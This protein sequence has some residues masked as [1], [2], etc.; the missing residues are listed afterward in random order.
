[1]SQINHKDL[2][3]CFF[4]LNLLNVVRIATIFAV[5][6]SMK[7]RLKSMGKR[8]AHAASLIRLTH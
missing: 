6:S 3:G 7:R 5:A 8:Q 1:M 2:T 4:S